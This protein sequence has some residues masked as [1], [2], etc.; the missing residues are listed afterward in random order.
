MITESLRR[1]VV[2]AGLTP[3]HEDLGQVLG[4]LNRIAARGVTTVTDADSPKALTIEDAGLVLVDASS[5]SVELTLPSVSNNQGV[6]Y[7]IVRTDT[8]TGNTVTLTPDGDDTVDGEESLSVAVEG[9]AEIETGAAP[10]GVGDWQAS[11]L[12]DAS[13]TKKGILRLS[14]SAQA[15]ELADDNTAL[16]PAKLAD[17]FKNLNHSLGPSGYQIFPGGLIIQWG[18]T[19]GYAATGNGVTT[20]TF[21]ISFTSECYIVLNTD[22]DLTS[23]SYVR[24]GNLTTTS[25]DAFVD[26]NGCYFLAIGV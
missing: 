22:N 11:A 25:F 21:P 9:R 13:E 8:E 23:T 10:A 12:R 6:S 5:G 4:A 17:A 15:Q 1:V 2:E 7:R 20:T 18:E 24:V 14:T 26:S 3:D 19:E 16:T